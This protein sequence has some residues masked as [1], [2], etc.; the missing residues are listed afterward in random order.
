VL[1]L[2]TKDFIINYTKM[3]NRFFFL[4]KY[5]VYPIPFVTWLRDSEAKIASFGQPKS[6]WENKSRWQGLYKLGAAGAAGN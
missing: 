5:S 6:L 2:L 3:Q 4:E 1:P